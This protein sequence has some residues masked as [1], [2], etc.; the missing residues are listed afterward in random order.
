MTFPNPSVGPF[1]S[2]DHRLSAFDSHT[3]GSEGFLFPK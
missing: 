1:Y 2:A 3:L